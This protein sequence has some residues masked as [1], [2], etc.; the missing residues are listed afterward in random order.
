[1]L[2]Y[3]LRLHRH[4]DVSRLS[5]AVV[6][7][8]AGALSTTGGDVVVLVVFLEVSRRVV[9]VVFFVSAIFYPIIFISQIVA[10][11]PN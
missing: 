9:L 3:P 6:E 1:M 8:A 11:I 7:G 5:F 4:L 10:A 2:N